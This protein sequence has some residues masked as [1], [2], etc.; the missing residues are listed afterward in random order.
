MHDWYAVVSR[1]LGRI[2]LSPF[3]MGGIVAM[4]NHRYLGADQQ[5]WEVGEDPRILDHYV[6]FPRLLDVK[7]FPSSAVQMGGG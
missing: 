7:Q 3:E 1:I 2:S 4:S 5:R 6:Y